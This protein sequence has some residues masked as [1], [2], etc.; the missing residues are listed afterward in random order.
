LL[1][2]G[3]TPGVYGCLSV[4]RL[5]LLGGKGHS[6][7]AVVVVVAVAVVVVVG[8]YSGVYRRG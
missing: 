1:L 3:V 8:F 2:E 7:A 6:V 4:P 5:A